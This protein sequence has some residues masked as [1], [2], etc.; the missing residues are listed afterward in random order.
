VPYK[1]AAQ[2]IPDLLSDQIQL[3][4]VSIPDALPHIRAGKLRAIA[5]TSKERSSVLPD[6]PTI[7]EQGLDFDVSAWFG[8]VAP[9][10]TPRANVDRYYTEI[11]K[12]YAQP[13]VRAKIAGIGM[14][15]VVKNPDQ[16]AAFIREEIARWAPVVKASGA[17]AD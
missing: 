14:D 9:A 12:T 16:F 13:E 7:A 8:L 5:V 6:V 3:M 15:P 10:G 2:A 11:A 1:G 17:K 4:F